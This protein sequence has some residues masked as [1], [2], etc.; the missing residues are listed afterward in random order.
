MGVSKRELEMKLVL[1]LEREDLEGTASFL[2]MED[3]D[4]RLRRCAICLRRLCVALL[5]GLEP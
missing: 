4:S 1:H 5:R 2:G 3:A